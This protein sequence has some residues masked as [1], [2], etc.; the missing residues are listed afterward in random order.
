VLARG[1]DHHPSRGGVIGLLRVVLFGLLPGASNVNVNV[2]VNV[3]SDDADRADERATTRHGSAQRPRK[4]NR[5]ASM[6]K[7]V[8]I[9]RIERMKGDS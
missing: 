6:T 7:V 8:R 2:N 9:T 5:P 4:T 3:S 1:Q